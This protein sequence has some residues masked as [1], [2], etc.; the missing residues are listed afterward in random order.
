MIIRPLADIPKSYGA[1]Q[2]T[3]VVYNRKLRMW[4]TD[5]TV[6]ASN[7]GNHV[8]MLESTDPVRWKPSRSAETDIQAADVDVKFDVIS[9]QFIMYLVKQTERGLSEIMTAKSSDG[10]HWSSPIAANMLASVA[11]YHVDSIGVSSDEL[12]RLVPGES[13][14]IAF[15]APYSLGTILPDTS[16]GRWSLYGSYSTKSR[17]P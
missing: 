16:P 7:D 12:G 13:V 5:T 2:P 14:L 10:M 1:G 11:N 8:Y 4:Y 9:S 6:D 3:V 15:G 17:Q